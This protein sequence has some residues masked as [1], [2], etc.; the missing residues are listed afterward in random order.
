MAITDFDF[1]PDQFINSQ[2]R[3]F[4]FQAND[5]DALNIAAMCCTSPLSEV[6]PEGMDFKHGGW[7]MSHATGSPKPWKK[8]FIRMALRGIS[9]TIADREFWTIAHGPIKIFK[10]GY[11]KRKNLSMALAAFIG[12]FYRRK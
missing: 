4:L 1:K 9:P 8:P 5:Q 2:E 11:I 12:R 3:T 6:G 7:I 10:E